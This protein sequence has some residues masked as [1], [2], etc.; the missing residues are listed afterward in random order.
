MGFQIFIDVSP[1]PLAKSPF[2]KTVNAIT[3][4]VCP[5]KV[6]FNVPKGAFV[7][8]VLGVVAYIVFLVLRVV[9]VLPVVVVVIVVAAEGDVIAIAGL[10]DEILT[11]VVANII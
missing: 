1:E 8:V 2:C 11:V 10:F 5:F 9:V 6:I 7:V 4:L 3:L